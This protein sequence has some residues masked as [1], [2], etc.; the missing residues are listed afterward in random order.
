MGSQGIK[1]CILAKLSGSSFQILPICFSQTKGE[2]FWLLNFCFGFCFL[3]SLSRDLKL[4][5]LYPIVSYTI[6]LWYTSCFKPTALVLD[7]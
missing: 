6:V 4:F 7:T 1:L 3:I 2:Y 5:Y